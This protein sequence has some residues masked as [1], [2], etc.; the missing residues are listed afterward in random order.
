MMAKRISQREAHRLRKEVERL[1]LTIRRQRLVWG[2]EYIGVELSRCT[3]KEGADA[4][5]VARKLGH[6]VVVLGDSSDVMR[7]VALPHPKEDI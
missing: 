5:R 6:A 4:A 3:F 2:Q 1:S 7:F